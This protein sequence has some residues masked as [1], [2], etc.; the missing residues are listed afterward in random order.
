METI[1]G[2]MQLRYARIKGLAFTPAEE[3]PTASLEITADMTPEIAE[4][5]GCRDALYKADG[6]PHKGPTRVDMGDARLRDVDLSLPSGAVPDQFDLYRPEII[7]SF[8]INRDDKSENRLRLHLIARIKGRF[9]DLIAFFETT[10][11]DEF[12]LA[13]RALQQEFNWAS[14]ETQGERVDI[15]SGKKVEEGPLFAQAE[16]GNC[17]A[18]VPRNCD[19][20]HMMPTGV[21][22]DC[23]RPNLEAEEQEGPAL[24]SSSLSGH[25][26]PKRKQTRGDVAVME[27]GVESEPAFPVQ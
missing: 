19:G 25:R 22:E 11:K 15:G 17:D 5:M 12:E 6:S 8:R 13:I 26:K 3:D 2:L 10:N 14:D 9:E 21:L 27:R 4:A 24:A 16:C 1:R 7:H 23:P 18:H 20:K